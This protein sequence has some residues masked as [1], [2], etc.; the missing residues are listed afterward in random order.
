M[1]F[2][3]VEQDKITELLGVSAGATP[4]SSNASH[5]KKNQFVTK[6]SRT[7][8]LS[9]SGEYQSDTDS[10]QSGMKSLSERKSV[11]SVKR[12]Y[13][14][15]IPPAIQPRSEWARRIHCIIDCARHRNPQRPEL[16]IVWGGE[17]NSSNLDVL[18]FGLRLVED[19]IYGSSF[20][21]FTILISR[22]GSMSYVDYLCEMHSKISS[23][24]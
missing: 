19:S 7:Y 3:C 15:E 12:M 20:F 21:K 6:M 14:G 16:K 9:T 10:I 5:L 18:R 4:L 11:Q 23:L 22:T 24:L 8:S 13:S 1:S 2:R 17:I